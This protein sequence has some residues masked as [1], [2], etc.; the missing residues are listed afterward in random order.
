MNIELIQS[1]ITLSAEQYICHQCNCVTNYAA[2][3]AKRIFETFPYADI[4][5]GRENPR[6]IVPE[7]EKPGNIIICGNGREQRYIINMMAQ[8][9]PGKPKYP[10]S[11]L[12]GF[13]V[14]EKA[15]KEC[16]NKISAIQNLKSIAFPKGI[17]CTLAGGYWDHYL[18]M[19]EE[20]SDKLPNVIVKLYQYSSS[21]QI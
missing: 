1:D 21:K 15:F 12:D 4:Y 20:F 17:G 5:S 6:K 16:L 18:K 3:L 11:Q 19:I 7:N 8:Y 9:F 14:R 13:E 2:G 10:N